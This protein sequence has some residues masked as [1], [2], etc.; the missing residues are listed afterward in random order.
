MKL[1]RISV[2]ITDEPVTYGIK[3]RLPWLEDVGRVRATLIPNP[4]RRLA[5]SVPVQ[6]VSPSDF[7]TEL[8]K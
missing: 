6:L 5:D 3:T 1:T 7:T 4:P 8:Y 2:A